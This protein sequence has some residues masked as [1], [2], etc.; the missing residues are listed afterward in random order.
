MKF[1]YEEAATREF[2]LQELRSL[3]SP[4]RESEMVELDQAYG[5]ITAS[6]VIAQFS[7]P[8][9]RSS[10]RDGI[11]VR[12]ED[13]AQGAPNTDGWVRGVN[14]AQ[15]DTGDDFPDEFDCVIA[16]ERFEF[17]EK[18]EPV[19]EK[20]LKSPAAGEGVNPCGS[21][22][23][24]GAVIVP[25]GT[26]L[27]PEYV[28]ICAVGGA[29]VIPVVK[30]PVVAF[31][32]TGSELVPWGSF[33]QRGQNIEANSLMMKGFV[34]QWGGTCVAYP[35]VPDKPESLE[36]ALDRALEAAD[37]VFING[38]SSRGEEDYNSY[39]LQRR[40]THF[41]HGVRAVPGRPV[42]MSI[43]DDRPVINI[44]GP[45][46]AAFLCCDWLLRGLMAHQ[47]GI[48]A[49]ARQVITARLTSDVKKMAPFERLQ[50]VTIAPLED[51]TFECTPL[52]VPG[53]ART[54]YESDGM[55]ALPI[56]TD[57]VPAGTL[58]NVELLR[59][60]EQITSRA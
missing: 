18:G 31:I 33:P 20:G 35:V 14:F 10:Q 49:P 53:V 36:R 43:I 4:Q 34:E 28:A 48:V 47:Q 45:V 16:R 25:A 8:V 21:I 37:I 2:A 5:R 60:L 46:A 3:W 42:G 59:P 13:F 15:A 38:G 23:K 54:I 22:V 32:P 52:D 56:G 58:V 50:R 27:T 12:S 39:M 41:R 7:L 44:P 29:S 1:D 17:N 30:K 57:C 11:A 19:F 6:D 40:G 51:G 9:K 24:A 26:R 55:L